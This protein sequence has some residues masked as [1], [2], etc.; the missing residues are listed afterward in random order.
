MSINSSRRLGGRLILKAMLLAG[1]VVASGNL[2]A[3]AVG[4]Q[5]ANI[6]FN[7]EWQVPTTPANINELNDYFT[8]PGYT[9]LL[10]LWGIN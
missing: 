6:Q 7:N 1:V 2:G 3:Q 10:V 5:A 4:S 9:T 8:P